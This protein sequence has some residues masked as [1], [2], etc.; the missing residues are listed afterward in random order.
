MDDSRDPNRLVPR[1][2]VLETLGVSN[3]TLWRMIQAGEFPPPVEISARRKGWPSSELAG[4]ILRRIA[5]RDLRG[6]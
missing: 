2:E 1:A 6:G 4:E 3:S 5:A